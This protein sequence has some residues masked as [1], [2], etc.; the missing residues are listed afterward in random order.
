MVQG[1]ASESGEEAAPLVWERLCRAGLTTGLAASPKSAGPTVLL[2]LV[3]MCEVDPVIQTKTTP[4]LL[5][6]WRLS[7]CWPACVSA[8]VW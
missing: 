8:G 2:I 5:T 6:P 1:S 7:F 3:A 4:F